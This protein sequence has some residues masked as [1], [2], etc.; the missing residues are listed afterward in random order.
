MPPCA[1]AGTNNTSIST[2]LKSQQL[3]IYRFT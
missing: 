1:S 2:S 3:S